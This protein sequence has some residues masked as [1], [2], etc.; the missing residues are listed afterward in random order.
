MSERKKLKLAANIDGTGWNFVGWQHPDMPSDASENID[1]YIQQAQLAEAA[2][3]DTLFLVDVSHVGAGNIPH[4]L[5][6]FEGMTIMSAISMKTKKIGLSAT[7]ATSYTDP[8]NVARQVL[9]L[10]KISKGR[11]SVNAVTSNPGGM[12]NFSRGHLT[13]ADQY[14]MNKEFMEILIGLWDTYEDDAFIRNKERGVYLNPNKMHTLNYRGKYFSV[15]GPLNLSRSVQGRPVLYTAGS[16]A[17]FID[18]ASSYTDGAFIHG[19]TMEDTMQVANGIRA[20]L[21]EKGRRP[22]DFVVITSQNP[23]VGNTDEEAVA[24]YKQLLEFKPTNSIPVPLFFGSAER[25][26]AQV[27][28]WYESGA[29]DMLMVRQD[30]PHGLRDFIDLVVPILQERGVFKTEYG[31]DTLRGHLEIPKPAFR[32]VG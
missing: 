9:S 31:G 15:A 14:P 11:A 2:K 6:M 26:A 16:S 22:E 7:I 25:V 4:Y 27:A 30:H 13:R 19:E 28:L 10:D 20:R 12:V 32:K 5:S 21:A 24:K 18:H 23:I 17:T 8:Y 3:F 1:F 29:M